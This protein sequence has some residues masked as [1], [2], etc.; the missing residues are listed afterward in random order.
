MSYRREGWARGGLYLAMTVAAQQDA[1]LGLVPVGS[2]R[3]PGGDG[4]GE[5]LCSWVDMVEMQAD[6]APAVS[7]ES[8]R[9]AGLVDQYATH[10]LV[11]PGHRFG[12]APFAA[13]PNSVP[14]ELG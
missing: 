1:L 14:G 4:H 7:A 8:A 3:L 11:T 5:E 6:D 13:P 2:Q 9:T 12:D 10:Q